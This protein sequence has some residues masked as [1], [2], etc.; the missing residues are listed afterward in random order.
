MMHELAR[1]A[2]YVDVGANCGTTTLPVAAMSQLH[3]VHG[4]EPVPAMFDLL[5]ASKRLGRRQY[6]RLHYHNAA[7]SNVTGSQKFFIPIGREDN[8]A[9]GP[10]ERVA[11]KN[12]VAR[13]K[14]L[15]VKSVTLDDFISSELVKVVSLLKIDTQGHELFVLKGAEQS[16]RSKVI[17]A[18]IAENDVHLMESAGVNPAEIQAF[19]QSCGFL[20]F[21]LDQ[22]RVL[23]DTFV[24]VQGSSPLL[25]LTPPHLPVATDVL[26]LPA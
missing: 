5:C 3:T 23:N 11:L 22:Y 4:F 24:K 8:A 12:V 20:P 14:E 19:M 17:Q 25:G 1:S 6:A 26:W 13:V 21:N 10:D 16:L 18:V 9:F 2:V 7:V 15:D